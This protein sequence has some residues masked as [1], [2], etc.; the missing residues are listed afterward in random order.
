MLNVGGRNQMRNVDVAS[1][2]CDLLNEAA[3]SLP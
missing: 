1:M 2:V 3:A